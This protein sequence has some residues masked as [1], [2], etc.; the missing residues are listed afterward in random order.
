MAPWAQR[1]RSELGRQLDPVPRAAT[2][3]LSHELATLRGE[4]LT[5]ENDV[6]GRRVHHQLVPREDLLLPV[7]R[8]FVEESPA[9]P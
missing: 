5:P 2:V 8:H 4:S 6:Y 7:P 9:H 1:P 3:S